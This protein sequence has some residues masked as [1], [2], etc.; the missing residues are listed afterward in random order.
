MFRT[1]YICCNH[2]H[3]FR[4]DQHAE[5]EKTLTACSTS[6]VVNFIFECGKHDFNSIKM[7]EW[8]I[9]EVIDIFRIILQG[10]AYLHAKGF[11][12]RDV[13]LRN[14]LVMSRNPSASALI[15][16]EKTIRVETAT[17]WRIGP[18]YTQ[19]PEI[20]GS[21]PY[22]KSSDMWSFGYALTRVCASKTRT[23]PSHEVDNR[24]SRA[25]VQDAHALLDEFAKLSPAHHELAIL[26]KRILQYEP[27]DR[28]TAQTALERWPVKYVLDADSEDE[29]E[30]GERPKKVA[31]MTNIN[32]T[33]SA[34]HK[35]RRNELVS[36]ECNARIRFPLPD[37][38]NLDIALEARKEADDRLTPSNSYS[39]PFR[40]KLVEYLD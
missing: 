24:Q 37:A 13:T 32:K 33:P 3:F 40:V 1:F 26:A 28:L 21:R 11:I 12:H 19:A 38:G 9:Q 27:N 17:S 23:L 36:A 4:P 16:F 5:M 30:R 34:E 2:R 22:D 15:D 14:M 20:D 35:D 31:K 39:P 10:I 29:T 25:W 7:V 8:G 6:D 18:I